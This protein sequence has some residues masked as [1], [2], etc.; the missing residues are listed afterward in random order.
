MT[1]ILRRKLG[2]EAVIIAN[3]AGEGADPNLNGITLE[4]EACGSF[5]K[6]RGWFEDQVRTYICTHCDACVYQTYIYYI[7]QT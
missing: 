6:C 1:A 4:S 3:T 2:P 5:D 7:Y